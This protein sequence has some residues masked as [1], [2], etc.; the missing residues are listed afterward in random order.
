MQNNTWYNYRNSSSGLLS[1]N[2][3]NNYLDLFWKDVMLNLDENQYVLIQFKVVNVNKEVKSISYIQRVNKNEF[4]TLYNIFI[5]FWDIKS[6]YYH[7]ME[8]IEVIFKYQI[9]NQLTDNIKR[10]K[11]IEHINTEKSTN[12]NPYFSFQGINLINNM[13][14]IQWGESHS[15]IDSIGNKKIIVFKPYTQSEYHI[16]KYESYNEIE[17]IN[18]NKSILK[19]K[20]SITTNLNSFKREFKNQ[21]IWYENGKIVLKLIKRKS[22]F[23]SSIKPSLYLSE[24]FITMDIETR[25]IDGDMQ[26]YCVSLYDG[27]YVSSFYLTEFKSPSELLE[28]AI[29][30]IMKRKYNGYKVYLHNFSKFDGVF[31]LKILC[32]LSDNVKPIINDNNFIKITFKFSNYYLHFRDS[33][34][35]LPSSLKKLAKGFNVEDKGIFPYLFVNNKIIDLNYKGAVPSFDKF[36]DL[37]YSKYLNYKKEIKIWDLKKECINYC[38]N[39]V[40]ILHKIINIF[41]NFIFENIR[42]DVLKYPTLSSLAFAIYRRKFIEKYKIPII[43][44]QMF[45]DIKDGYT[46]GSV[47]VFKPYG[48]NIYNYDVNSLYPYVMREYKMPIGTPMFFEGDILKYIKNPFGFFYVDII[49]PEKENIPFLQ[50]RVKINNSIKTISPLGNWTG[51]YFSEEINKAKELGYKIKIIKGYLFDQDIIFKEYVD[52]FYDMKKKS[53]KNSPQYIISKLLLNSLY[54]RLG[55]N[56]I[57]NKHVIVNKAEAF[58]YFENFSVTDV[59]SLGDKEMISILN[60]NKNDDSDQYLGSNVC[61]AVSAAVTAYARIYMAQ[62][63]QNHK[64]NILYTDTDSISINKELDNKFVGTEIGK[65]KLEYISSKSIFLAPKVYFSLT[66]GSEICKIKGFKAQ[67]YKNITFN[68]FYNLLYK[69]KKLILTQEKWFKNFSEGKISIINELYT[70]SHNSG[71]RLPIYDENNKFI[72]TKPLTL[73][74]GKIANK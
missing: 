16:T 48:E 37:D 67:N 1:N 65:F 30:S 19:F 46:G 45:S 42:L 70:L 39:D 25:N 26:A 40:I 49:T 59:M 44:G 38:N 71:K 20:D 69:N 56:P 15:Y 64:E 60:L 2:L 35:L 54:G 14:Y 7:L 17:I 8:V 53:D 5:E 57:K 72:E 74:D 12:D 34:L 41:S 6:E 21:I 18:N 36:I 58:K 27:D 32:K 11:L 73:I 66:N 9:L 28:R 4:L 31:L 43:N 50:K 22:K 47:E 3:I 10:S 13:D 68:E 33:Y 61:V 51:W 29:L 55:M 63:K 52:Y 62:F 24:K 23:I